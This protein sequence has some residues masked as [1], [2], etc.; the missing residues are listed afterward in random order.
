[1]SDLLRLLV[2]IPV[3]YLAA[4]AAA[5]VTVA[6][7]T[8]G[9][10]SGLRPAGIVI[11][12]GVMMVYAGA[13]SFVPSLI[14]ITASELWRIRSV[15]Y[16]LI[17]GG[18]LGYVIHQFAPFAGPVEMY[19]QRALAFPAAGFIGGAVYWFIAGR[20]AGIGRNRRG[21]EPA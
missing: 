17:F 4:D 2:L 13:A 1:M 8:F 5:A 15:F 11:V 6:L 14:A 20:R 12:S 21:G 9:P 10:P 16:F 3:G 18:V 19:Q 7:T